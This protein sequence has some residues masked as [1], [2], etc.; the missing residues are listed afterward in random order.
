MKKDM[1]CPNCGGSMIREISDSSLTWVCPNCGW[2]IATT[3]TPPIKQDEQVYKLY[4][5][6]I[7][8]PNVNSIKLVSKI[9]GENLMQTK[10][11]LVGGDFLGV[12]G[13]ASKILIIKN[14]LE[15][16]GILFSITPEFKY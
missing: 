5:L 13:E 8:E 12:E 1:T 7:A 9:T 2:N 15:E 6:K 14:Q 16:Q 10:K 4:L 3:Y 11:K